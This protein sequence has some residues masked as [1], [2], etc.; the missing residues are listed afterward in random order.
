MSPTVEK[1]EKLRSAVKLLSDASES[2]IQSWKEDEQRSINGTTAARGAPSTQSY[3]AV[4]T[5][6]GAFGVI[7]ELVQVPQTRLATMSM[8]YLEA[9]ALHIAIQLRIADLL[10]KADQTIGMPLSEL[11]AHTGVVE[12][13][14][15]Q[16]IR[17][18]CTSHVFREVQPGYFANNWISEVLANNEILRASLL[19]GLMTV[20]PCVALPEALLHPK[21]GP[22]D[23]PVETAFQLAHKTNLSFWDWMEEEIELPDG[24][25]GKRPELE[26]FGLGMLGGGR[27]RGSAWLVDYPWHELSNATIVDVGGGVGGM[28]LDLAHNF[29]NMKF[30]VQD[31]PQTVIQAKEIWE[32]E[33][34]GAEAKGTVRLMPHDFFNEQPVKG[35][36]VYHLRN[37]LHDWSDAYCI[38]ILKAL[39][40]ALTAPRSRILISELVLNTTLGSPH[41]TPAPPPLPANYGYAQRQHHMAD[42]AMLGLFNSAERTPEDWE[43]L[44]DASGLVIKRVWETRGSLCIMELVVKD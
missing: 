42:I 25:R 30:V 6:I 18:L 32:R 28:C 2:L 44:A 37:I 27:A 29:P 8:Q 19:T 26:L 9:R 11:S 22:S 21:F 16:V 24:T 13:K 3:D 20:P 14:L 4:R 40:P 12:Q 38:R 31:R 17:L 36:D 5:I 1:A 33:I 39:R 41:I 43:R 15:G 35:A 23:S 7:E 34:P 10:A